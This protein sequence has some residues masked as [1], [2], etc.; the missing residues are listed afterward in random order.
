MQTVKAIT[1]KFEANQFTKSFK[2]LGVMPAS[3]PR[4]HKMEKT[5]TENTSFSTIH[6]SK[7]TLCSLFPLL[8]HGGYGYPNA[9][10][11][12]SHY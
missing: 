10:I 9:W 6:F 4:T 7:P 11:E 1:G 2:G 12:N 8:K 3:S 5:K